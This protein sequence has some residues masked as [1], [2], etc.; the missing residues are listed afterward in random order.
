MPSKIAEVVVAGRVAFQDLVDVGDV[1]G[2]QESAGVD[3]DAG[4]PEIG[5]DLQ[6]LG[7]RPVV[8]DCVV[9]AELHSVIFFPLSS[10]DSVT[11]P[12]SSMLCTPSSKR[13]AAGQGLLFAEAGDLFEERAGL[14][15]ERVVLAEADFGG[16]H[17]Q[18]AGDV[19]VA[20][21]E[22]DLAVAVLV[23]GAVVEEQLDFGGAALVELGGTVLAEHLEDEAVGV[24]GGDPGDLEAAGAVF[25]LCVE[26]GVVVVLDG[27]EGVADRSVVVAHDGARAA[28][29][30][31]RSRC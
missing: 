31:C 22:D 9:D 26:R 7:K 10:A 19:G 29:A 1:D 11:A 21:A 20:R 28:G 12:S 16:V 18:A 4:Q 2:G 25:E 6:G 23:A 17:G 8:Q 13:G 27:F 15:A 30:A 3:L 24:A 14:V 5:D